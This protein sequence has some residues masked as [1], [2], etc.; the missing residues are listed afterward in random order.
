MKLR[1]NLGAA[2]ALVLLL[3]PSAYALEPSDKYVAPP[4]CSDPNDPKPMQPVVSEHPACTAY[5]P[6]RDNV[7]AAFA[8]RECDDE[9]KADQEKQL[10]YS[11]KLAQWNDREEV[12]HRCNEQREDQLDKAK[13]AALPWCSGGKDYSGK[14]YDMVPG[15]DTQVI[16]RVAGN[17]ADPMNPKLI[18]RLTKAQEKR[19][20]DVFHAECE[21]KPHHELTVRPTAL[22]CSEIVN[23]CGDRV[24]SVCSSD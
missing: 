14:A 2:T 20:V 10:D 17:G 9:R 22:G 24:G 13:Y 1:H 7:R 12:R 3:V 8:W 16:A 5:F 4:N 11:D 6:T 18:C 23:E 15:W 21:R 19:L